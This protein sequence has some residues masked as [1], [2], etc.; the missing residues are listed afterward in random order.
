MVLPQLWR[1]VVR[2]ATYKKPWTK[3]ELVAAFDLLLQAPET[4]LRFCFFI[5]GLDEFDG[6][7]RDLIDAIRSFGKSPFV[8]I[9]VSS[10]P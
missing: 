5:D 2:L 7:H 3:S 9:C 1:A 6:D 10:R 8:K 4:V